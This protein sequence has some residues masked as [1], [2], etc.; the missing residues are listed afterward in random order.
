MFF[1]DSIVLILS[2]F[3]FVFTDLTPSQEDKYYIGWYYNS[4][5]GI[6]VGANLF[7]IVYSGVKEA[8]MKIKAKYALEMA[9]KR[10]K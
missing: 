6:L 3:M 7:V 5:V 8:I 4:I 1:N 10:R 9:L 2:Y